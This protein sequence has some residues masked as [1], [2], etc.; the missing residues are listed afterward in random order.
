MH[1]A[2]G[3]IGLISHNMLPAEFEEQ[4]LIGALEK[5]LTDLNTSSN[6]SKTRF[7]LD[8]P[9]LYKPIRQEVALELYIY[10]FE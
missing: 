6:L 7:R 2:Y 3:E 8:N 1:K 5:F 9:N 10:C 4:G